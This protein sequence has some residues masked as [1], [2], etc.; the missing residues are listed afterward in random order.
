MIA[1]FFLQSANTFGSGE[2]TTTFFERA[3]FQVVLLVLLVM[4]V[5]ALYVAKEVR[6]L[7]TEE[8]VDAARIL[9][10]SRRHIVIKHLFSAPL[11]D[12]YTR[13][14]SAVYADSYYFTALRI[15]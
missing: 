1:Y 15:T 13:I 11:Y 6:K 10:G 2:E 7:R 9:G 3:S 4:P 12:V 5:I 8:F 14:S